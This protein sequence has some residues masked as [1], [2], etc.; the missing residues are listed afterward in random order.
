MFEDC[1]LFNVRSLERRL[2]KVA[3]ESFKK[4]NMH[5]T[6]GYILNYV[7]KND[8]TKVIEIA[9]NI[10]L[11]QSTVTRMIQTLITDGYLKKGNECSKVQIYLTPKG[12]QIIPEIEKCWAQFNDSYEK[13]LTTTEINNLKNSIISF[14]EKFIVHN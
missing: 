3:I 14:K 11:E 6:H 9:R 12:E 13:V 4:I 8:N 10:D 2:S 5:P 1:L 7:A